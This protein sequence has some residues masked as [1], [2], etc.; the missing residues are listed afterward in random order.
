MG[1]DTTTR[2]N[3]VES[4]G[5]HDPWENPTIS[6]E[7]RSLEIKGKDRQRRD[8]RRH[9]PYRWWLLIGLLTAAGLT[10]AAFY[11]S[12]LSTRWVEAEVVQAVV[13]PP[14]DVALDLA[15]MI[16]PRSRVKIGPRV[17]GTIVEF[18]VQE[19]TRLKKGDL[20]ARIDD[21]SFLADQKDAQAALD[22]ARS[23]LQELENGA[24][25][26]EIE[27]L[28]AQRDEAR[29]L[30][31]LATK[32]YGRA[33][34]LKE[35][36]AIPENEMDARI[37]NH[38]QA[39]AQL[40]SI[41]HQL[42]LMEQGPRA[43]RVAIAR[44]EVERAQALLDKA[45][46]FLENTRIVAPVDCTVLE[47]HVEIGEIVRPEVLLT[48][49]CV[50]ADLKQMDALVDVQERDLHQIRIGQPCVIIPDAYRDRRYSGAV[51][52]IHPQI[53]V[54][55]GVAKIRVRI[56][57]LDDYLLPNMNCR[58]LFYAH[59][60]QDSEEGGSGVWVPAAAVGGEP[61]AQF[62]FVLDSGRARWR[63]VQTDRTAGRFVAI[64]SGVSTGETV[65]LPGKDILS[66]G[67][68][69]R[70]AEESSR[71]ELSE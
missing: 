18:P 26:D 44:A 55:R 39:R 9:S 8:A 11:W 14:R 58:V 52:R 32:E 56:D 57:D 23:R 15:A 43:E 2:G 30:L 64:T 10:G 68:R 35:T 27:Q 69:V 33:L 22:V 70:P 47:K 59:E 29:A 12:R 19:G 71:N 67:Q 49:L 16:E 36:S 31:A 20:V 60:F 28:R 41:E 4:P 42:A 38:E 24:L 34:A 51:D 54:Q 40:R 13:R 6:G 66:E 46:Y 7:L 48:S 21:V 50:L 62:V 3:P 17:P 1:A 45:T 37:A 65:I 53:N 63:S 25:E 5:R 61:D